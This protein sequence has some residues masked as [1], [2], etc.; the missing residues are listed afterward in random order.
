MKEPAMNLLARQA[1]ASP[2]TAASA[3]VRKVVPVILSGGA[4]TRL[5]PLSRESYPKQLWSLVSERTL[6][7][8]TALRAVG[9]EFAPPIIVCNEAH[10]FLIAE[11][12]QGAAI[13]GARIVLEPEGRNTAP[14][15]AAAALLVAEEDAASILWMMAADA[16]IAD[17]AALARGLAVALP[18]ARAG[19]VVTFGMRPTAPESGY[20]WIEPGAELPEAPGVRRVARFIEKPDPATA[21]RLLASGN[22]LWNS[23]MFVFT[24]ATLLDE[25]ARH[26]PAVLTA[27]RR[28]V[29]TRSVDPD[30]IRLGAEAFRAAPSISLDFALAERTSKASVVAADFGW[31]DVGSWQA[32]WQLKEK[33]ASGNVALGDV[34]L[35]SATNCYVRSEGKL[36]AVV[37][38]ADAAVIVTDDAVLA[39]HRDQ[40]QQ[41]KAV[42]ERLRAQGRP[43]A[44]SHARVVRPWG[45]YE[46]LLLGERF[47]VKRIVVKPGGIL[48]LQKHF[49]RAEHWTVVGGSALVT[50]GDKKQLLAENESIY[51]PLGA[52]HRMEN[53]GRIPMTLIEVQSGAY[54]GEDD[55]VRLEDSYGRA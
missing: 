23:G 40:A 4:G 24:A 2:A 53:P 48:S 5:W 3:A 9:P 21:A 19:S 8:D 54:L 26:A 10:R 22:S 28:A 37:G 43:E 50:V 42:V 44:A 32:L 30:F 29:E 6:I 12:M 51:I 1:D 7:Q 25:L 27:A 16:A 45:Y 47:Q 35:E 18:A 11:Q 31:S 46:S 20:G 36:T 15:I 41:V 52:V 33:D 49:H 55:I 39:V 13:A 38:L 17:R 14:A 34:L